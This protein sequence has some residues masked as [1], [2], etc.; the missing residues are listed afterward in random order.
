MKKIFLIATLGVAGLASAN[1]LTDNTVE[2]EAPKKQLCTQITINI[3]CDSSQN[4]NN[5]YCWTE[6]NN[7]SFQEA[8]HCYETEYQMFNDELCN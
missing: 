8:L 2:T 5:T 3:M 1:G 6:G 7:A 4:F